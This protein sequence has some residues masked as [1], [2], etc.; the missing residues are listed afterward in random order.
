MFDGNSWAYAPSLPMAVHGVN[1]AVLDS[2]LIGVRHLP[3]M[4][5]RTNALLPGQ[6]A[7]K[8][9]RKRAGTSALSG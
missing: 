3:L 7:P 4:P 9:R 1:V 6:N 8:R 2:A 5:F